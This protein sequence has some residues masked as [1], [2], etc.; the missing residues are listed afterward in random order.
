M[1]AH[2][3]V[4]RTLP[5]VFV[6]NH[7][8]LGAA[9]GARLTPQPGPVSARRIAAVSLAA[10]TVGFAAHLGIDGLPHWT[11]TTDRAF[12]IACVLDGLIGLVV[13]GLLLRAGWR[14]LGLRALPMLAAAA[15]SATPD[16]NK[17]ARMFLHA[18]IYPAWWE[19]WHVAVQL[20]NPHWWPVELAVA[21]GCALLIRRALRRDADVHWQR[22]AADQSRESEAPVR[23]GR[24]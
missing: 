18:E 23:L 20:Q 21:C 17:P 12:L 15:G 4:V 11:S 10:F 24:Q 1:A 6:T 13:C 7:V 22:S 2:S 19:R 3:Q 5:V 9:A 8:L 16:L 14:T